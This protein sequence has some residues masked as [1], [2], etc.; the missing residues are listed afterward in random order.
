MV[1]ASE[2][3]AAEYRL[4][5]SDDDLLAECD[6]DTFRA[7]GPGGQHQNMTDSGVRL[8]HR[9]T[10]M[11]VSSRSERSQLQNKRICLRRLRTRLE[12]LLEPPAPRVPTRPSRTAREQRLEHKARR[13]RT[14]RE[15][16]APPLD[17]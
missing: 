2:D 7:G 15:R 9:P 13:S 16:R 5:P 17:E 11:T 12:K 6:V 3:G 1:E 8:R 10:G 14:K 4:P